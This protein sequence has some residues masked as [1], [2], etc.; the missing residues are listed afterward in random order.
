MFEALFGYPF[1]L[2]RKGELVLLGPYPRW[3]LAA[4]ILAAALVL[5][6]AIWR[7][8][9]KLASGLTGWRP[10]VVWL[11][12]ACLVA[13]ILLLLWQPALRVSVLKPQQNVIALLVDDSGS[14]AIEEQGETRLAQAVRLLNGGLLEGLAKNFQVRLYRL[15]DRLERIEDLG[16]L[17]A[18]RPATRIGESLRELTRE[19]ANLPLGAVV[20]LS[21]GAENSGGIDLATLAEIRR[22]R[23]P[24]HAIGFGR[25]RFT[26]DI[27]ISDVRVPERALAGSRLAAAVTLRQSGYAGK[28]ARLSVRE[29]GRPLAAKEIVLGET[30]SQQ[31]DIVLFNAGEAGVR[32]LEFTIEALAGE[33]NLRNNALLRLVQVEA[34]RP[35]V[36]YFEGEPRW[37]YKFIRRALA[38]DPV[39]ELVSL[40]RTTQNKL[41]RQGLNSP[42]EL[43]DG[44]PGR[45][46][47]LFGYQ[48]LILGSVEAGYFT[49]AQQELIR[50]F[51]DR[52]GGG[53]L[54]LGGRA[55]LADGGWAASPLAE[56]LPVSLP[57]Q[58]NTFHRDQAGVEL[59][60]A[61]RDSLITRLV[62]D[63]GENVKRWSALPR[64]ADYQEVSDP[65]PGATVLALLRSPAG[66][67]LPLLVTQNY[68]RGRSAVFA[69][70]GSWR[71]QMQQELTDQTHEIFWQ[72][73][74][75][76]LVA[77]S[78]S[79]VSASTPRPVLADES[80]V[81]LEAVVRDKTYLP[82]AD[83]RVEARLMG[84][85]GLSE[86]IELAPDPLEPG[87]YRAEWRAEKPGAYLAE[88]VAFR[89]AEEAG[90]DTIAF[91]REDGVA[92]NFRAEQNRELLEKLAEQT[93][94]S[95]YR[96][97]Q[98]RRLLDEIVY[99]EA[100]ITVQETKELW[101]LP[102]VFLLL[103]ALKSAEW[104]LRRRWGVV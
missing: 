84:P 52:R 97:E 29:G 100:G 45:V 21:D 44:F 83:A 2:Y 82:A 18:A 70:G 96:P 48:A 104:F 99:S 9:S 27:E 39:V 75:R 1:S 47:E 25:E 79:P 7:W 49:P 46:E 38:E 34:S 94:G 43:A 88:I 36:L 24:V 22:R 74:V 57:A 53:I 71:W 13:I 92:E 26:Q 90:R 95:Y 8:R 31:T 14:M 20:L 17:G 50:Q 86:A 76:W 59:A 56:L 15:S 11:L 16:Q 89:G 81:R 101:N 65:K 67:S 60:P 19:A 64:L 85:A 63:A 102:A 28:K 12:Q 98:A 72:Q 87:T 80:L 55:A 32:T 41:Y 78:P 4:A 3:L 40:L 69:T 73:L 103:L 30:G 42:E 66:R 5:G 33:E 77:G 54:F 6:A 93:G 58:K 37:E 61:G 68:G 62:E 35:R 91:R 10:A 23:L 51:V